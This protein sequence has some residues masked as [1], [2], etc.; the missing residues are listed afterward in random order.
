MK[1]GF[2]SLLTVL[3]IGLKLGEVID[4]SWW[5]VLAPLWGPP[6]VVIVGMLLALIAIAITAGIVA[7][8]AWITER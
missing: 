4:W 1:V 5:W 3:F 6:A 7:M 2:F 8:L